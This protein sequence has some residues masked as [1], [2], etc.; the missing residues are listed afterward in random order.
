[1]DFAKVLALISN[2]RGDRP[3]DVYDELKNAKQE[4][5]S[6]SDGAQRYVARAFAP[7]DAMKLLSSA[8]KESIKKEGPL[9]RSRPS[10]N[11]EM[12]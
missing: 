6:T 1:M 9:M 2:I 12:V 10:G 7:S 5:Y 3:K 11:R 8:Q 4:G